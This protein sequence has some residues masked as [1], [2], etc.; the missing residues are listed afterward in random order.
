MEYAVARFLQLLQ[1]PVAR[2][3]CLRLI[4]SHPD[5]PALLCV[6]DVLDALGVNNIVAQ[7][8]D[9]Q[10]GEVPFPYLT[11]L[12]RAGGELLLLTNAAERATARA[13]AAWTG[14]VVQADGLRMPP[15]PEQL[16]RYQQARRVA[17]VGK[18]TAA[19]AAVLLLLPVFLLSGGLAAGF[20]LAALL[21]AVVGAVLVAKDLGVTPQAVADFC[22]N[23][24]QAGCDEVLQTNPVQLFGLFTLS[25]ATATYFSWQVLVLAGLAVA[26]R[27]GTALLPLLAL[28]AL[29]GVGVVGFSLYYQAV[30]A[31]A[32][33][34]LCLVVDAVLLLQAGWGAYTLWQMPLHV[35]ASW[36]LPGLTAAGALLGIAGLVVVLKQ[37][38]RR[39]FDTQNHEV[40]LLRHKH[41]VPVFTSL[42]QQQPQADTREFAQEMVVGHPEAPLE[43]IMVSNP[44]CA[45]CQ[46]QHEH[47]SRLLALFPESLKVRFRFTVSSADTGRFPT[48]T[49]YLLHH[50]LTHIWNTP[51]EYQRTAAMLHDWYEHMSLDR[52]ARTHPADFTAD[53]SL[54]TQLGTQH[55]VWVKQHRISRTPTLYLNGYQLPPAYKLADLTTMVPSLADFFS[56]EVMHGETAG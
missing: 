55:Y 8:D 37:V 13:S 6:S 15:P 35:Q 24:S 28:A 50:W 36:L 38:G 46:M 18:L 10:L 12:D 40:A 16:A 29:L 34:R 52:F 11:H 20:Y 4:R 45:P 23:S 42:L 53:Y 39:H 27:L 3:E 33:C 21:G 49:Q 7:V 41:S 56:Q 51:N 31:K 14:I 19:V 17:V 9:A 54:S 44:F 48:T 32:W 2:H 1:V 30:V 43:I 47:L 25:D 22:G 5:Y 26:P